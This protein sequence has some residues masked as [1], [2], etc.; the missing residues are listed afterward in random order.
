MKFE[1]L[2]FCAKNGEKSSIEQILEMYKPM[3][4]KNS[5]VNGQFDEDMYQEIVLT[6]LKCIYCFGKLE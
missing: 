3:M 4:I 2:L 1:E 5:L 6:A